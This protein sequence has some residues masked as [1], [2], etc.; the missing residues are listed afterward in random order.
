MKTKEEIK[1]WFGTVVQ[2]KQAEGLRIGKDLN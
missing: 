2:K 1:E